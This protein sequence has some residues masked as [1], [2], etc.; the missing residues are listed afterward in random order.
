MSV[1][2]EPL[3]WDS[4]VENPLA[5][6]RYAELA[7]RDAER[8]L[9]ERAAAQARE[10]APLAF[11]RAEIA[12][13]LSRSLASLGA[14][15]EARA[16]ADR[17]R[18]PRAVA[19]IT[20]QQPGFLG[21]PLFTLYK[22][23]HAVVLARAVERACGAPCIPLFWN[24]SDDHDLD[25]TRGISLVDSQGNV[26]RL[27]VDLG[28][29]RPFLSDV[30]VPDSAKELGER[31]AALLPAGAD[32]DR[33]LSLVL[34]RPGER[35]AE[36]ASRILLES[37][38][39]HGLV[40]FE[41]RDLRPIL[42]RAL[43]RVARS[44]G[45]G[46]ERLRS[47]NGRLRSL[48]FAPPFDDA[49]PALVFARTPAGRER[50][51]LSG[52]QFS[53]PSGE[54]WDPRALA[55]AIERS[56]DSFSAG[57]GTRCAV[58]AL[59][60]PVVAT[61]RGPGELLY[62]PSA[63][64]FLPEEARRAAPVEFPRF[65]ATLIESKLAV[66]LGLLGVPAADLLRD[67]EAI[68]KKLAAPAEHPAELALAAMADR[69]QS[70][71]SEIAPALRDL[72]PNLERP[73]EKTVSTTSG[74]LAALRSKVRRSVEDRAGVGGARLRRALAWLRPNQQFQERALPAA[75]FLVADF[76]GRIDEILSIV[77]AAPAGHVL[78]TFE[79][80]P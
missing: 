60:L 72:D 1:S 32:R 18:D 20:G 30:V 39:R 23:A 75:P 63:Y 4:V 36:R 44:T 68:H 48:G 80:H 34:P 50:I 25:E 45:E 46:L 29:G 8:P 74:A 64:C 71:L 58:E 9:V 73:L 47:A 61:I 15:A 38:G 19:V 59:A 52:H 27:A 10:I 11:E 31:A 21:G 53:A 22:A 26:Q 41:P 24:H 76:D 77:P 55:A 28:R 79:E 51:R 62:T 65:S 37:L 12:T 5:R 17:L 16:S 13:Q 42:S 67:G 43:A 49:D 78:V 3:S 2:V 66:S 35:F 40:V 14:P 70:Q 7:A 69:L 33:V 6:A 54:S 57:V 56:P